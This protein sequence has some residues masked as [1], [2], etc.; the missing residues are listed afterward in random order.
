MVDYSIYYRRAIDVNRIKYETP[1]FDIFVSAYNSSDRVRTVFAEVPAARKVWLLHP[2]YAYA[3]L[4]EPTGYPIVRP[5]S[6]DEIPQV[7]ALLAELGPLD[8]VHLCVDITGFMRHVLIFLIAKLAHL[9]VKKLTVLYSEPVTYSKQE[10]TAFSTTTSGHVRPVRGMRGNNSSQAHD[11]L[12]IAVGYDHKLISEVANNKDDARVYPLF[13][14]PSLSADMYQQSA[15]RAAESGTVALR[16]EW[17]SKRSFAPAND[18]F[19]TASVVSLLVKNIDRETQLANIYLSP[20]STKVQALGFAI[21][22]QLE[23][24]LRQGSAT[25]LLPECLRYSRETSIGVKRL[26]L[27]E[28]ELD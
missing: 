17:I 24:R 20:L 13:A 14:F 11:H 28:V 16:S 8:G 23:G 10:D 9:G 26:W 2:E 27:Y 4:E 22:W 7:N 5:E 6:I 25:I 3:P 21:Y 15:I 1:K 19:A 12:I 18:P